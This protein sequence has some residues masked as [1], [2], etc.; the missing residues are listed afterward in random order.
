[1]R[2]RTRGIRIIKYTRI[3]S[4]CILYAWK[5]R[6]KFI[7]I[8]T[9]LKLILKIHRMRKHVITYRLYRVQFPFSLPLPLPQKTRIIYYIIFII[10]IFRFEYLK[11][12]KIFS[13]FFS[14]SLPPNRPRIIKQQRKEKENEQSFQSLLPN[15]TKSI[16]ISTISYNIT[17]STIKHV[18]QYQIHEYHSHIY[19]GRKRK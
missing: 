13:F 10:R 15:N 4:I 11:V 5:C 9:N 12:L 19:R 3:W 2:Y 18:T 17:S 7:R 8:E 14:L 1:M 6:I 16:V